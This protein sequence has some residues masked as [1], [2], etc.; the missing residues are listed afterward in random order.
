M[1][2]N[3]GG[4]IKKGKNRLRK[5]EVEKNSGLVIDFHHKVMV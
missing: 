5:L 2:I 3:F 4:F 1:A